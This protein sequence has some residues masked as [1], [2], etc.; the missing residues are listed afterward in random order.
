MELALYLVQT[1]TIIA[2][3]AL[4]V[5]TRRQGKLIDKLVA[6]LTE[7]EPRLLLEAP[8]AGGAI[9]KQEF[10]TFM[11]TL[12]EFTYLAE[13]VDFA[14]KYVTRMSDVQLHEVCSQDLTTDGKANLYAAWQKA[15]E[16]KKSW[17]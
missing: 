2:V 3:L 11:L 8:E 5:R 12:R 16:G 7:G 10:E 13:R 17:L 1:G 6:V 9:P 14:A 15:K 4:T